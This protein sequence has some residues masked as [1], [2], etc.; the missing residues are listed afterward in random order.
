MPLVFTSHIFRFSLDFI[1]QCV[2]ACITPFFFKRKDFVGT[3]M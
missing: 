2:D 1:V 3:F